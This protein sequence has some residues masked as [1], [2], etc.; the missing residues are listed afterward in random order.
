VIKPDG[1]DRDLHFACGWRGR[2]GNLDQLD[3]AVGNER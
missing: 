1:L 3:F 2:C